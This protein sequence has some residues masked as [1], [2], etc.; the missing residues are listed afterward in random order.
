MRRRP[1][2]S[3]P[4]RTNAATPAP[5]SAT[6]TGPRPSPPPAATSHD[7]PRGAGTFSRIGE[8]PWAERRKTAPAEPIVEVTVPYAIPDI[9]DHVVEVRERV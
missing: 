1:R 3:A 7:Y 9:A 8:Y 4:N 5:P 2:T 6:A